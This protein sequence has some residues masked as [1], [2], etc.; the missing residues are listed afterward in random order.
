M[1]PREHPPE[2]PCLA[3]RDS[4]SGEPLLHVWRFLD[5]EWT[6]GMAFADELTPDE[7]AALS[8][9]ERA[10]ALE[11]RDRIEAVANEHDPEFATL[12]AEPCMETMLE[13]RGDA[14]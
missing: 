1:I 6:Q 7:V 13:C 5:G 11:W 4:K 14:A 12:N 2:G 3:G 9:D 10:V 8:A